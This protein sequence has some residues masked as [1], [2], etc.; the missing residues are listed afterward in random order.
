MMKDRNL[1]NLLQKWKQE[2]REDH[3]RITRPADTLHLILFLDLRFLDARSM[4]QETSAHRKDRIPC[5][6]K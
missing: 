3:Y 1:L 2:L 6:Q 4:G 5:H